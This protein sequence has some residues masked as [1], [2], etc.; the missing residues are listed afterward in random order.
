MFCRILV[1]IDGSGYAERA[2]DAACQLADH[3]KARVVLLNVVE[4]S[5]LPAALARFAEAEH[6]DKKTLPH[7]L[8]ERIVGEA[9]E[10]AAK[11]GAADVSCLVK[12]GDAA[13]VILA[14]ARE[15]DADLIVMG[16][17]G[18]GPIKEVFLGSV[19]HKVTQMAPCACMTVR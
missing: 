16:S 1:P 12:D 15:E 10:R 14:T 8:G 19:S 7:S 2:L 6:L 4:Q 9:R 17:R 13:R 3:H 5:A 11:G 18:L